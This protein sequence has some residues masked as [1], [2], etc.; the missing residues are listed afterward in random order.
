MSHEKKTWLVGLY[1]GLYILPSYIGIIVNHFNK[2]HTV[3]LQFPIYLEPGV[4][5]RYLNK[6]DKYL[7]LALERQVR[8][9]YRGGCLE[10]EGYTDTLPKTIPENGWLE[11]DPFPFGFRQIFRDRS[12][13]ILGF[14]DG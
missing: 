12:F 8:S 3:I 1:K 9:K 13:G 4:G 7:S 14:W 6:Y 10:D 2:D 5:S 11:D